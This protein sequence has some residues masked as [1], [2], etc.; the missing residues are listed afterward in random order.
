MSSDLKAR[1]FEIHWKTLAPRRNRDTSENQFD[2]WV[3]QYELWNIEFD[4]PF[5]VEDCRIPL[6]K[7]EVQS[8]YMRFKKFITTGITSNNT[9]TT[10]KD[11]ALHF[12][13]SISGD[14]QT[15]TVLT[16]VFD[17]RE[18]IQPGKTAKREA[19]V[20]DIW[21]PTAIPVRHTIHATLL[22]GLPTE[23]GMGDQR[24]YR[25][26]KPQVSAK[27]KV[28][29][30]DR[31][32]AYRLLSCRDYVLY[33]SIEGRGVLSE[34]ED[35][36]GTMAVYWRHLMH[37]NSPKLVGCIIGN[38]GLGAIYHPVFHPKYPLIAFHYM[39]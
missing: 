35:M 33:Q 20:A 30:L 22:M 2:E 21:S 12:P 4:D 31:T 17:R 32:P 37:H 19:D 3:A 5:L 25:N 16:T 13:S 34:E 15:I 29:R 39:T 14:L 24:A 23:T 9:R 10:C 11:L 7:I 38:S 1:A 27:A 26:A 28:I 18:R 6:D 36:T 8:Q